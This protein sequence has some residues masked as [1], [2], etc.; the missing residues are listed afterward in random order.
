M[1]AVVC[2]T[3]LPFPIPFYLIFAHKNKPPTIAITVLS[4]LLAVAVAST[5]VLAAFSANKSATTT[6]TFGGGVTLA[7]NGA[8]ANGA[9]DTAD[10]S[11]ALIWANDADSTKKLGTISDVAKDVKFEAISFTKGK[12]SDAGIYLIAQASITAEGAGSEVTLTLDGSKWKKVGETNW[13]VYTTNESATSTADATAI[14]DTTA[15]PFVTAAG[16]A[17][18]D[19]ITGKTYTASIKVQAVDAGT[20]DA[21]T[22]LA[23]L[24]K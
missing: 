2:G 7:V 12:S 14:T 24:A 1:P 20:A 5:I 10:N 23:D 11:S 22:K 13:Y 16:I 3:P 15:V 18:S 6:I 21:L 4:I 19:S 9:V 8:Y 17:A